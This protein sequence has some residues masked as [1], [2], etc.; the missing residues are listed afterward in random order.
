ML[1]VELGVEWIE[2][3]ERQRWDLGDDG[4]LEARETGEE[5]VAEGEG[6]ERPL[7]LL[8]ASPSAGAGRMSFKLFCV[9]LSL[10]LGGIVLL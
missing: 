1:R 4:E 8:L 7:L 5:R 10:G 6:E 9:F 3:L 2:A